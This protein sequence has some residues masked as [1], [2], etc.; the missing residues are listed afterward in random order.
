MSNE[1]AHHHLI[2]IVVMNSSDRGMNS[3]TLRSA[4]YISPAK[5]E[6]QCE[7][8][9]RSSEAGF[10][11]FCA[12]YKALPT[13]LSHPHIAELSI[14]HPAGRGWVFA[15]GFFGIPPSSEAVVDGGAELLRIG[16]I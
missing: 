13:H 10:V 3:D 5:M 9:R 8:P 4:G 14:I 16:M 2:L 7:H 12:L 1:C 15:G 11:R 6:A